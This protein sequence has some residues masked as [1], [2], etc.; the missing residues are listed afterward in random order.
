MLETA[1]ETSARQT[2]AD[3]AGRLFAPVL[4]DIRSWG[5]WVMIAHEFEQGLSLT[6]VKND[7]ILLIEFLPMDVTRGC[8]LRTGR[9]N[10]H[11][12]LPWHPGRELESEDLELV[13]RIIMTVADGEEH[14]DWVEPPAVFRRCLVR[15]VRV[16]RCLVRENR[17]QYYFNPYVGCTIGCPFC[18]AGPC[19]RFSRRLEAL[20]DL[21]WGRFLD[22]K[23]NAPDILKHEVRTHPPGFVRI[24]PIATD[25]YQ[26]MER[27]YRITRQSLEILL[28]AG[29]SPAILTRSRR[30]LEDI[31]LLARFEKAIVGVSIPTDDDRVRRRF[32][33]GADSIESR[34]EI[35]ES[36]SAAGIPTMV[37]VQ[38]MLPMD[39]EALAEK[40]AAATHVVRLDRMHE[41]DS[42]RD[43]Y[44]QY[45]YR[46]EAGDEWFTR[47]AEG[48]SRMLIASGCTVHPMDD[49]PSLFQLARGLMQGRS[50]TTAR[51][52]AHPRTGDRRA[53]HGVSAPPVRT[54]G[55]PH[56]PLC[57]APQPGSP[58][59]LNRAYPFVRVE[60]KTCGSVAIHEILVRTTS[61]CNQNCPFC[62]AEP[63]SC[64]A[65]AAEL[66]E[67]I[68]R[69][70]VEFPSARV[71][72][73]GGEPTLRKDLADLVIFALDQ[74]AV[75]SVLV[76]TNA[77]AIGLK[78]QRLAFPNSSRL[79]FFVSLHATQ[80]E[81][82][83]L[84]TDSS[85]QLPWALRGIRHLHAA[86]HRITV[87][88]VV[89][90]LNVDHLEDVVRTVYGVCPG[91]PRL[92]LHFSIVMCPEYRDGA[93]DF[94]VS[95]STV[96]DRLRDAIRLAGELGLPVD[97]PLSSTHA[98]I[99][100]CMLDDALR[101]RSSRPLLH[102]HETGY[103]DG[104]KSWVKSSR[105]LTCRETAS[106]LGLPKAYAR[107][108]GFGEIRPIS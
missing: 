20:P 69:A 33:P 90:R 29:F 44:D 37:A 27:R 46:T 86:G 51:V 3:V 52:R 77:V 50:R 99:P 38:P 41:M 108:F 15:E 21:P 45:G 67:S 91:S 89:N 64:E 32:E 95:Y 87:N 65:T 54:S 24:S 47:T 82:Y 76:Q 92:E 22:V 94:L 88:C 19:V 73:T 30:V 39:P 57:E 106:C 4:Q 36:I 84:T 1:H 79:S 49:L 25:P 78:P 80:P 66:K 102:D 85:R 100:A 101:H 98:S 17:R 58:E 70:A 63:L 83:N 10:V 56:A 13:R 53:R 43:I 71:T 2:V 104:S 93:P 16:D 68:R 72:L 59:G 8:F 18:F 107:R 28:E 55:E 9:F 5:G 11:Y 6:Y 60:T 81:P 34:F 105:C 103:E 40:I 35:L 75:G 62:S 12:S 26:P 14:I 96:A 61:R 48:L 42:V 31:D 97:S 7:E 23:I 74:A